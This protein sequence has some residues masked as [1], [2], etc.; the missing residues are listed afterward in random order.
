MQFL[1]TY[2]MDFWHSVNTTCIKANWFL[3]QMLQNE[4]Q[5]SNKTQY[6]HGLLN[7]SNN[8]KMLIFIGQNYVYV[9][10]MFLVISLLLSAQ[11][12]LH[13]NALENVTFKTRGITIYIFLPSV[14]CILPFCPWCHA[15]KTVTWQQWVNKVKSLLVFLVTVWLK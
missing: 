3:I 1:F 11:N 6:W 13:C 10:G 2:Q 8:I 4:H 14:V 7:C 5:A 15:S 9:R 12:C